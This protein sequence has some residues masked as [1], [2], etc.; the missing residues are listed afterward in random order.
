MRLDRPARRQA[1]IGLTPLIDVVFILLLFFMLTTRFG[2]QQAMELNL[3][4]DGDGTSSTVSDTVIL[5]LDASGSVVMPDG[6]TL[7][8]DRLAA[9]PELERIREQALPVAL[10]V[11]DAVPLQAL[12]GVLDRFDAIGLPEVSVRG[13][14]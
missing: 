11:D 8:L 14:R 12:I 2:Q 6:S 1:R 5:R 7:A 3:R 9:D 10:D 13:L 4:A